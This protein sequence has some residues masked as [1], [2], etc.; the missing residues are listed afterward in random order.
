MEIRSSS[1]SFVAVQLK[2]T[3]VAVRAQYKGTDM[4]GEETSSKNI[5]V[6]IKSYIELCG[7]AFRGEHIVISQRDYY[8]PQLQRQ[9]IEIVQSNIVQC[10]YFLRYCNE[11][12]LFKTG[13]HRRGIITDRYTTTPGVKKTLQNTCAHLVIEHPQKNTENNI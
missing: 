9:E 4:T 5:P 10:W 1:E 11:T 7:V 3:N 12:Y 13:L 2:R 6:Q 8:L